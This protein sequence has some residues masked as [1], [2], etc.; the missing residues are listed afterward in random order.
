MLRMSSR[1]PVPNFVILDPRRGRTRRILETMLTLYE[2]TGR[3]IAPGEPV[4]EA[5]W[6]SVLADRRT[7]RRKKLKHPEP[8]LDPRGPQVSVL[9]E[10]GVHEIEFRCPCLQVENINIDHVP[11]HMW[12][13]EAYNRRR[14][15]CP[16]CKIE[17]NAM[18]TILWP[19][20]EPARGEW[21]PDR[22]IWGM[23]PEPPKRD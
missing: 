18:L 2:V 4:D 20:K 14:M 7:H 12:I 3:A 1:K 10:K 8:P 6:D 19:P 9:R 11:G 17:G 23:P 13:F 22:P 21:Q 15:V 16:K 5:W